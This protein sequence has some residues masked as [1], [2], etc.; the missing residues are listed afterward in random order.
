MRLWLKRSISVGF[1]VLILIQIIR[2]ARTN[3]PIDS[4]HEIAASLPVEPTLTSI[5]DRSCNDCHSN[6]TVWPWYSRVAPVS[7]LV[8]SDVQNGRRNL[9]FSEWGTYPP[10]K[11]AK[12]LDEI[13]KE[14]KDGEMPPT[15]YTPMHSTAKLTNADQDDVCRW[16]AT[17]RQSL[18]VG[19]AKTGTLEANSRS[20]KPTLE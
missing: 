5:L 2:R 18:A 17:A 8:A 1:V 15:T 16:T 3:P 6:R 20:S 12:L 7:W 10:E 11:S 14:V 13:C 4:K 19:G 9:N